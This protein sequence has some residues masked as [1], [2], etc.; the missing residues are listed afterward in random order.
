[1]INLKR[2]KINNYQ[3]AWKVNSK[4]LKSYW[5]INKIN[6]MMNSGETL[7]LF[8]IFEFIFI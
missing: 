8:Q 1:M 7:Y 6:K 5:I 3:L 2:I 4:N